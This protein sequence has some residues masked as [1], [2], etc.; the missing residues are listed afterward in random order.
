MNRSASPLPFLAGALA[1]L[2]CAGCADGPK[3]SEVAGK[4]TFQGQPLD[5]G[6]IEFH[7][8]DGQGT[9]SGALVYKGE[10]KIPRSKGLSPGRYKVTIVG[11][12]G[13]P[14]TGNAEPSERRPG[15]VPGRTERIPPE[16]NT[17]SNVIREVKDSAHTFDF[18]IP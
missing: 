5:E 12:D 2:L 8:L 4:V 16:Y 15:F 7:P 9:K 17:N 10:Y 13:A 3:R 6:L 11:G 1:L 18:N 14:T